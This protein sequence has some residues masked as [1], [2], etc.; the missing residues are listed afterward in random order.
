MLRIWSSSTE[1]FTTDL[2]RQPKSRRCR[3][4]STLLTLILYLGKQGNYINANVSKLKQAYYE[5]C[6][7]THICNPTR[8]KS[9]T[10][11]STSLHPV[12]EPSASVVYTDTGY[13]HCFMETRDG[14]FPMF[15]SQYWVKRG[16]H[17][18]W[19]G[20]GWGLGVESNLC[21]DQR[22]DREPGRFTGSFITGLLLHHLNDNTKIRIHFI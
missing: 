22:H 5:F 11:N 20:W 15:R 6:L 2:S 3:K 4:N 16:E 14:N 13:S 17:F 8:T 19:R 1:N 9:R 10:V 7:Y 12:F 21:A 18:H